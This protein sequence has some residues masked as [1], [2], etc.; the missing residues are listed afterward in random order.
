MDGA[1]L[2]VHSMDDQRNQTTVIFACPKCGLVHE[3]TQEHVPAK[4]SGDRA[5]YTSL[6]R[7]FPVVVAACDW[8]DRPECFDPL[9]FTDS[10]SFSDPD[11]LASSLEEERLLLFAVALWDTCLWLAVA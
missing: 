7:N 5:C 9:A 4:M 2:S 1:F 11:S 6:L 10:A 3:V 8:A